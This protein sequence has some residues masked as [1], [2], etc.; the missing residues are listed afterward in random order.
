MLEVCLPTLTSSCDAD[1][2]L[3]MVSPASRSTLWSIFPAT[4]EWCI[5][6]RRG[7]LPMR[8]AIS[9]FRGTL[10][11]RSSGD[12]TAVACAMARLA[13]SINQQG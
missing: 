3:D 1:S 12:G 13:A 7:G 11:P 10:A 9:L 4:W 6:H 5:P 2:T 8:Q